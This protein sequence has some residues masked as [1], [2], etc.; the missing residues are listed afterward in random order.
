[1]R[2]EV[3]CSQGEGNVLEQAK[4]SLLHLLSS[5]LPLAEP[6]LREQWGLKE[7][8]HK[9]PLQ[10]GEETEMMLWSRSTSPARPLPFGSRYSL[11]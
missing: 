4:P 2:A 10:P 8:K 5:L 9:I 3:S 7:G 1:M 6:L 11:R